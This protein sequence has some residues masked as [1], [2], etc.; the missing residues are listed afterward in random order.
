MELVKEVDPYGRF[1]H[2]PGS[3][4]DNGKIRAALVIGGFASA[5][6]EV[7]KVGTFGADKY[8]DNGWTSVPDALNRYDDAKVRHM[9]QEASGD[10]YDSDSGLLHAAHEAWNALAKL[11]FL[12]LEVDSHDDH[13]GIG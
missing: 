3:K 12:L 8:T 2:E 11:H 10:L 1:Q 6:T 5:L 7:A 13:I 4:L 9:L